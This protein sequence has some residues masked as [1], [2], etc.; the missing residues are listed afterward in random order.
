MYLK[1]LTARGFKSFADKITLEFEPGIS[2]IVGPNGSGKSNVADAVLWVLGEQSPRNM[3]AGRMEDVIFAGSAKRQP[4]NMAEVSLSFDNREGDIPLEFPEIVVTRRLFRTGESEYLLNKTPCR[5]VDIQEMLADLGVGREL[6]AVIGQ[7]RLESI[8]R[9]G[10]EDR[11]AY[12]EEISGLLKHRKRKEKALRKLEGMERNLV[13]LKDILSEVA[14]QL[15]PLEKQA[16]KAR[17]YN[18][19]AERIRE[20]S[21]RLLVGELEEL[22]A[23]WEGRSE[24]EKTLQ[25]ELKG[26]EE[27]MGEARADI[28][29]IEEMLGGRRKLLEEGR[30]EEMRLLSLG[31]RLRSSR[32]VGEERLKLYAALAGGAD[33]GRRAWFERRGRLES[34]L[35]A[36]AADREKMER[37]LHAV[38][39][40]E[41]RLF[42]ERKGLEENLSRSR[43]RRDALRERVAE[44][45][46]ELREK[47]ERARSLREEARAAAEEEGKKA[48]EE[49]ALRKERENLAGMLR[50]V[51]E[52]VRRME[53]EMSDLDLE[54]E[55]MEEE[56]RRLEGEKD[57]LARRQRRSY[58][59]EA[60]VVARLRALQE[61]FSSRIDFSSAAAHI[62]EKRGKREGILG[63]VLHHME[64][65]AEWE[66]AVESYLGPWLFCIVT[67]TL[68]DA[69]DAVRE[70]KEE[71]AGMGVFLPLEEIDTASLEGLKDM[72]RK[73]GGTPAL[74]VVKGRGEAG[75]SLEFL[76]SDVVLCSSLEEAERRS[77]IYPKLTFLTVDG[78]V[79]AP[80][81]VVKGGAV[82]RSPFHVIARRKEIEE[83]QDMLDHF[84]REG[85]TLEVR[86]KSVVSAMESLR[87]G[88]EKG[89]ASRKKLEGRLGEKRVEKER[90]TLRLESLDRRM[91]RLRRER[92]ELRAKGRGARREAAQVEESTR[93][94]A[95]ELE[96]LRG[97][98]SESESKLKACREREKSLTE[99]LRELDARRASLCERIRNLEDRMAEVE[100]ELAVP[101]P[102]GSRELSGKSALQKELLR[103]VDRLMAV[104]GSMT[105]AVREKTEKA[106]REAEKLEGELAALRRFLE[107]ARK[108]EQELRERIH[109]RDIAITRLKMRVDMVVQRL[110][111][112]FKV[113]LETAVSEY[114]P[115][116]PMEKMREELA[117][118]EARREALGS[119]NLAAVEECERLRERHRF[120]LEQVEDLKES[121]ASL[122][123]VIRAID[124]EIVRIF[125][126]TFEE[127]NQNFQA[128][129]ERLF[130]QGRAE[131]VLTDPTDLLHTGIDIEAQPQ[132]KRL[133]KLSLLSGGETA[134]TSLAFLF[135]L[136]KCR[137]SPFYFLDEVEAA[138]DDVNLHRFLSMVKEFKGESQLV[139]ITHQ[140]RTMEIA[141]VLYGMSMQADG[142]SRVISQKLESEESM[143]QAG[144]A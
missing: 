1:S 26:L 50:E 111:D 134:L 14:R 15:R 80:R 37:E 87:G 95:G 92:E 110:L 39:E 124:R 121:K 77:E 135:A 101:P 45:E 81:R 43:K 86:R 56:L 51:E 31:E 53:G 44:K 36:L 38:A 94:L 107:E 78:D 28:A 108:R 91:D 104:H 93:A 82:S 70:L 109:D 98:L 19:L 40:D 118:L 67:R 27:R 42:L 16:S 47:E 84:D 130:P 66:R 127:V 4:M 142:V 115:T 49:E 143:A 97:D 73:A 54:L 13:R 112:D 105:A 128:L 9:S 69:L 99:G 138:L 114:R 12:V 117:V 55:R 18:E 79:V 21:I 25:E 141:D 20:L 132:G 11:R 85:V 89:R 3:R 71:E 83:L 59:E 5:L 52:S 126:R 35:R 22:Q 120:L 10:P 7:N 100:E 125:R 34:R 61:V 48:E 136:F 33:G 2:V 23:G 41:E 106:E 140:K 103:L 131:L 57:E 123:K 75:K 72:A 137:P 32:S 65:P 122:L 46:R 64:V 74:D 129:F 76:L 24:E 113:P 68:A 62:L 102:P 144:T 6:T 133:K 139:I 63:M 116:A 8:L 17:E 88:L 60:L 30:R 29:R 96:S 119:V 90:L 58:Q